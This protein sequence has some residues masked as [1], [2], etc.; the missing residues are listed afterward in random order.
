M[1]EEKKIKCPEC[2][3]ADAVQKLSVVYAEGMLTP[4]G[5]PL[6]EKMAPP[7]KPKFNGLAEKI[8]KGAGKVVGGTFEHIGCLTGGLV[9]FLSFALP[10]IAWMYFTAWISFVITGN[11]FNK[12]A[13][14]APV[15]KYVVAIWVVLIIVPPAI[16]SYLALR[17]RSRFDQEHLPSWLAALEE[18]SKR[19]FC[20]RCNRTF[21]S[22]APIPLDAMGIDWSGLEKMGAK[23]RP[24]AEKMVKTFS[25][26]AKSGHCEACHMEMRGVL[27]SN[28]NYCGQLAP[29]YQKLKGT[30]FVCPTCG[31][32]YCKKCKIKEVSV[33]LRYDMARAVCSSCKSPMPKPDVLVGTK[34]WYE[35]FPLAMREATAKKA[36]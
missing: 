18:W 8:G 26:I 6:V 11:Q 10:M 23:E 28:T 31:A 20:K 12:N 16:L 3:Q 30:G 4:S 15:P 9:W 35:S 36:S 21:A 33:G 13:L 14:N 17:R 29:A 19:F 25:G 32:F 5:A 34:G 7:A 1:A 27:L 2:G 22:E 24:V